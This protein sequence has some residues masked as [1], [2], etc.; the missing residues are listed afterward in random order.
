MRRRSAG[1]PRISWARGDPDAR[2]TAEAAGHAA[3]PGAARVPGPRRH[4]PGRLPVDVPRATGGPRRGDRGA[5][6]ALAHQPR[7]RA[8]HPAEAAQAP[9]V[10]P[11]ATRSARPT[12][13]PGGLTRRWSSTTPGPHR[14]AQS[15]DALHHQ[16]WPRAEAGHET[17]MFSGRA[18][19]ILGSLQVGGLSCL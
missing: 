1:S 9:D 5:H 15:L 8:D 13:P 3:R 7:R 19:Y 12:F 11:G 17:T 14:D 18:V 16:K 10:W 6:P 2:T 4:S